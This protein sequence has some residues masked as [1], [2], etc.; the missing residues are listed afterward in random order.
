MKSAPGTIDIYLWRARVNNLLDSDTDPKGL[1]LP[2]YQ[3]YLDSAEVRMAKNVQPLPAPKSMVE[4]YNQ[5]A[6]FAAY[7]EDK[8]KAKLY[9]DKALALDPENA[10]AKEGLKSLTAPAAKAPGKK[11]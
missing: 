2:F 10:T 5:I 4:A 9:W 3:Q 6:G 7:K 11:K 8:A 1:K